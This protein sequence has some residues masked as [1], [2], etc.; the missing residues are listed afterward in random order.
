MAASRLESPLPTRARSLPP[1]HFVCLVSLKEAQQVTGNSR[2]DAALSMVVDR[3]VLKQGIGGGLAGF[4]ERSEA[5]SQHMELRVK[6]R[7]A[8]LAAKESVQQMNRE[9]GNSERHMQR[10]AGLDEENARSA[11]S[12]K[13]A[14]MGL[15]AV[16]ADMGIQ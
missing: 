5:F 15:D 6:E 3:S 2:L 8:A 14:C 13:A 7:E 11:A 1:V 9:M 12:A 4:F 10:T 16:S